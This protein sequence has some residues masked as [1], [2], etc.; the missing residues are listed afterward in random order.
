MLVKLMDTYLEHGKLIIGVDFDDTVYPYS[1]SIHSLRPV[2]NVL[3][4]AIAQGHIIC[5]HTCRS[6][7]KPIAQFFEQEGLEF[8][9]FNASPVITD[10]GC[11]PYFNILLDDKACLEACTKEL[12]KVL[13]AIDALTTK[14]AVAF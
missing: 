6:D 2:H 3:K 13:D 1:V 9:Y 8:H 5:L 7:P 10:I 11:K 12:I 4:R 14:Q